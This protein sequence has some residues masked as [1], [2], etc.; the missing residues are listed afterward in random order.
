MTGAW[1]FLAVLYAIVWSAKG[2][3]SIYVHQVAI[4]NSPDKTPQATDVDVDK[5]YKTYD[6]G[7]LADVENHI[8]LQAE[9]YPTGTQ[10]ETFLVRR[11]SVLVLEYLF[12]STWLHIF[13]SQIL[14]LEAVN[15]SS[16]KIDGLM[17]YYNHGVEQNPQFYA[18]YSFN[19]WYAFL[20][21][22]HLVIEQGDS[23]LITV[24]GREFLKYLIQ[25]GR[26]F[27][28]RRN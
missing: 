17:P 7:L 4:A 19:S 9:P 1:L 25:N 12:E 10:R 27:A 23:V 26:S 20:K 11:M 14:A 3:E 24:R 22:E 16:M 6:N 2:H 5:Y 18:A 28:D 8:K 15:R 21:L 13:Q